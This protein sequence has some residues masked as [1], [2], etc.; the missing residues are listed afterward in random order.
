MNIVFTQRR[1]GYGGLRTRSA[2]AN[3]MTDTPNKTGNSAPKSSKPAVRHVVPTEGGWAV[4]SGGKTRPSRVFSSKAEAVREARESVQAAGGRVLVRGREGRT[5]ETI[6]IG[7]APF[8]K[9]SAVEGIK[10][11]PEA[12][13]R[14]IEFEKKGLSSEERRH[15][16]IKAFRDKF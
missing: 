16:I 14:A 5:R 2:I 10:P 15:A 4:T 7:R 8:T 1:L 11:T 12:R 13:R 3:T 9:I 6:T